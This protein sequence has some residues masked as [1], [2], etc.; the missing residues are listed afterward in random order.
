VLDA[1]SRYHDASVAAL[2]TAYDSGSIVVCEI[3]WAEVSAHFAD[4]GT[5]SETMAAIGASFDPCSKA[6]AE[7]AG[8]LWRKYRKSSGSRARLIPDFLIGAHAHL[9]TDLLLTRDRGFYRSYF[10]VLKILDPSEN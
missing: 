5:C 2:K 4:S 9:H 10:S 7:L 8:R 3:V 1:R 6:S